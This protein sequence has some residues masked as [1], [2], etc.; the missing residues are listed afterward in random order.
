MASGEPPI[1]T[2]SYGPMLLRWR[3][4]P[5]FPGEIVALRRTPR[6][7]PPP[8]PDAGPCSLLGPRPTSTWAFARREIEVGTGQTL[9]ADLALKDLPSFKIT[10]KIGGNLRDS[11]QSWSCTFRHV[12]PRAY[13]LFV[14]E[15]QHGGQ[16]DPFVYDVS[17]PD[18]RG[19]GAA[20]CV[21]AG[22]G[23]TTSLR[24]GI[25]PGETVSLT[26]D[27]PP[28]FTA[29][30]N[31]AVLAPDTRFAWDS[32]ASGVYALV[33][34]VWQPTASYPKIKVFTVARSATW[35][36]LRAIG[37]TFP[38]LKRA[39]PEGNAAYK[40][41]IGLLQPYATMDDATGPNGLG[42]LIPKDRRQSFSSTIEVRAPAGDAAGPSTA[43]PR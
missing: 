13:Q 26:G 40:C 30:P 16:R 6:A 11:M 35:P 27:P 24:C 17:V 37:I 23:Y 42:A 41:M 9:T 4:P 5:A 20:L 12:W 29:P 14:D 31:G 19:T 15:A 32:S 2:A 22:V 43:I 36:D 1:N 21:E 18:L 38:A 28:T 34:D 25:S 3:G 10:L 33:F 7:P 39:F 8:P